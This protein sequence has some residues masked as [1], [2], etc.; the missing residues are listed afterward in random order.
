[1]IK[2]EC[3]QCHKR[4]YTLSV[5]IEY[6]VSAIDGSD[7]LIDKWECSECGHNQVSGMYYR[8]PK[9]E[10]LDVKDLENRMEE[11]IKSIGE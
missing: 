2:L 11:Y 5:G 8:I 6:D 4:T 3:P 7:I 10:E 9:V 1:M